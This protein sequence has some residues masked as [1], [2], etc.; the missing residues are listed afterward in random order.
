MKVYT[1][2]YTLS[3]PEFPFFWKRDEF[4]MEDFVWPGAWKG[5]RKS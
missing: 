4:P 2:I 3:R 1:K 5:R